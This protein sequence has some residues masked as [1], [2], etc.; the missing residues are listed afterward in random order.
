[1]DD[2]WYLF[3]TSKI[4]FKL[5]GGRLMAKSGGAY[6]G[7]DEFLKLKADMEL[8]KIDDLISKREWD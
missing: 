5:I 1:L 7:F 6:I 2:G 4:F 3:G 8:A